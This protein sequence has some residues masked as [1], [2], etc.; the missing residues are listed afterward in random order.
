MGPLAT[1]QQLDDAISGI[2]ELRNDAELVLGD[3]V[4]V[5]G[6]ANPQGR[7]F[8]FAPTLLR[9]DTPAGDAAV[10]R[11][12]VF[13]PVATLMPYDGT[14]TEVATLVGH[15]EGS[16]VTSVY[17]D[18]LGFLNAYLSRGGATS[19]RLYLGSEKA[20]AQLPGSGVALPQV[21]HGGP[22]RAGGGQEL[23]GERGLAL[24]L[25]RVAVTGDRALIEKLDAPV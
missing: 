15:A 1:A 9:A 10:H 25:N 7:G 6:T 18:D 5:D 2:D 24:Y 22:G 19:G 4:R 14:A 23:G 13:G 20:A 11:R 21:L 17:S 8:F 16:L 3:G 12:E